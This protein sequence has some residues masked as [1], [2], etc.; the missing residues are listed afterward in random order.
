MQIHTQKTNTIKLE[1]TKHKEKA[2]EKKP[3]KLVCFR[4]PTNDT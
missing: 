1:E 3:T 2:I 4:F